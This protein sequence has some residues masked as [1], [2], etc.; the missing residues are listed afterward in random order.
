MQYAVS[1]R[2]ISFSEIDLLDREFSL[3]PDCLAIE[4]D[5]GLA[6]SV[7]RAGILHPPLLLPRGEN[8]YSVVAG[9]RRVAAARET[10]AEGWCML[11]G[12]KTV[13]EICLQLAM[14]DIVGQRQPTLL[15]RAVFLDKLGRHLDSAKMT[16]ILASLSIPFS[17]RQ[18]QEAALILALEPPVIEAI[19]AGRVDDRIVPQLAAMNMRDR[20]SVLD[21]ITAFGLSV[22]NQRKMLAMAMDLSKRQRISVMAVL[23]QE[24]VARILDD[25]KRNPPQKT[26]RFMLWLERQ[27]FP[28]LA[29]ELRRFR[30]LREELRLP[31]NITVD[32]SPFFEKD[33]LTMTIA[34]PDAESLRRGWPK[35][36]AAA[37]ED[38]GM[39]PPGVIRR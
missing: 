5:R 33:E 20:L 1:C 29:E 11:L 27:C 19:H 23:G 38:G 10:M 32:H 16:R 22:G 15:E 36:A 7:A 9:F 6:A 14:E 28:Q 17:E 3:L 8:V 37:F 34:W 35:M 30:R 13:P 12:A 24:G 2:K 39:Q 26:A 18:R 31:A 4:P 21:I 25:P